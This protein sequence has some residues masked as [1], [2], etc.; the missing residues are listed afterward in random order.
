MFDNVV[1]A[2]RRGPARALRGRRPLGPRRPLAALGAHRGDLRAREP[3]A[4]LLPVDGVPDRPIAGEQHHESAA[5]SRRAAI[6]RREEPRLAGHARAGAGRRA[7][8]RRAGPAG[9]VLPRSMATMQLPAMGYGLRYEYG[10]FRQTIE[11]GWQHEQPDNWLR[12][13]DPWEVARPAREGGDPARLLVRGARR[14]PARRPGP[15]VDPDRHPV[16]S[17]GR[18]LR[19]QDDQHAAPLGRRRAGSTSTFRRSARGDFVGA[20]AETARRRVAHARALSRRLD[21]HGPGPALRAGVL[22][23]RLLAGRSR[24]ALPA[25]QHRLERAARRRSRSSSTT[26]IRRWPSPS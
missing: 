25:R 9:R 8:Q 22:P 20:L 1:D 15:A 3:E 26:R 10:I 24:P 16:R 2:G 5:R 12:R 21:Q 7:G 4:R 23:R 6:R 18:R 14:Q 19:R 11:D 13:P 17:P